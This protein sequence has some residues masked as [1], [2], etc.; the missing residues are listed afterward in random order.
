MQLAALASWRRW[1]SANSYETPQAGGQNSEQSNHGHALV[2]CRASNDS[3]RSR[4]SPGTCAIWSTERETFVLLPHVLDKWHF[5]ASLETLFN[6]DLTT[7]PLKRLLASRSRSCITRSLGRESPPSTA[8]DSL[9]SKVCTTLILYKYTWWP[10]LMVNSL[11]LCLRDPHHLLPVTVP[12]TARWTRV[13]S[14]S[15][16]SRISSK[17]VF[18]FQ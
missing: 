17:E 12:T 18:N 7:Y 2:R 9:S 14:R 8:R 16:K 5:T 15:W 3:S 4:V 6:L 13:S 10:Y 11:I 1:K